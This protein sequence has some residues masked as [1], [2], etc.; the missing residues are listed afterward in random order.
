VAE[1]KSLETLVIAGV[2][3]TDAGMREI[4]ELSSLTDLN[5]SAFTNVTNKGLRELAGLKSLRRLYIHDRGG[6]ITISGL[7]CLNALPGLVVLNVRGIVQDNSGLDISGLT[8]LEKLTLG[9]R[10]KRLGKSIVRDM[11]RDQDMACL[12]H[13][14]KLEWLQ[15]I[16]GISDIGLEN[17]SG[18]TEMERLGFIG[19]S[20]TDAGLVH[21]TKMSKLD[22][23]S[24]YDG[25]ITDHGLRH[26]EKLPN[27][28]YLNITSRSRISAAAKR[29]L[30]DHLPDLATLNIQLKTEGV[31]RKANRAN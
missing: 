27:L 9:L 18:L 30:R 5:L 4:A 8:N 3:F 10:E 24:I 26:L 14:K 12:A 1:L 7:S 25:N 6:H 16:N 23:L 2:G 20:L 29:R 17:L 31:S 21:L 15:G 13:L 22:H 19:P 11:F 28:A